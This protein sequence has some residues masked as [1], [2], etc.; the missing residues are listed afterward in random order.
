MNYKK[1]LIIISILGAFLFYNF[2]DYKVFAFDIPEKPINYVSDFANI[3]DDQ[4]EFLINQKLKSFQASTSNE[5]AIVTIPELPVNT[6]I[7]RYANELFRK[8]GIGDKTN[9][10]GV[11]FLL[12]LKDRKNR[13]EVGYGLEGALTDYTSNAILQDIKPILK[14]GDYNLAV[15][16]VV[17]SIIKATTGEYQNTGNVNVS[18]SNLFS[19]IPHF[20]IFFFFFFPILTAW[21]A[22]VLGRTKSWWLGGLMGFILA[23]VLYFLVYKIL[24][25]FLFTILGLIFDYFVSKNYKQSIS[26]TKDPDWWSGGTWGP[27]GGWGGGGSSDGGFGGFGGGS[28]G[29]GGSSSDW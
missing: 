14:S 18:N 5:I 12:S 21:L 2:L 1:A 16:N 8:W 26:S 24:A 3:I 23:L 27:G 29:G 13:I 4:E 6:Y 22:S 28:S 15:N 9:N 10:N 17:D 25:W 19:F 20:I 7:E 11:L